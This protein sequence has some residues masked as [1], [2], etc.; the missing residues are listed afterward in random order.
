ME[1]TLEHA[2]FERSFMSTYQADWSALSPQLIML[3][4]VGAR[5]SFRMYFVVGFSFSFVDFAYFLIVKEDAVPAVPEMVAP[6]NKSSNL[7]KCKCSATSHH[8]RARL[9]CPR[10]EH[11]LL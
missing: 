4:D 2:G 5:Y 9:V 8:P 3:T 1:Y 10:P 7:D 6:A 11:K